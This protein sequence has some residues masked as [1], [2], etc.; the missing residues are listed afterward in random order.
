M[1]KIIENLNLL[2][3][4]DNRKTYLI[5]GLGNPGRE[6]K[7]NRHNVGFMIIDEVSK[8][9][10]IEFTR[11]QSNAMVTKSDFNG[12][13]ILLAKPYSYM[14][15]SGQPIR[16]LVRFY[17]IPLDNLLIIYDDVDLPFGTIRLRP[18]GSSSGQKGMN[19]IIQH[20]N[21]EEFNRLRIGIGRP[22]GKMRT[23]DY[24]LQDFKRSELE[25]LPFILDRASDAAL[26]FVSEGIISAMNNYNQTQ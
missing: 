5:A 8:K 21:S 12:E 6:Y 4:K 18:E 15:T 16:S 24:V 26:S 23:P 20:L 3:K 14:N 19:S 2:V 22:P 17:K 13:K 1:Q 7:N 9:L 10:G 25:E 11:M